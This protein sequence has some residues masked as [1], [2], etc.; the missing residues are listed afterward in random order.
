MRMTIFYV[1]ILMN[2]FSFCMAD[3][4]SWTYLLYNS[5]ISET[6][7]LTLE[8]KGVKKFL[9]QPMCETKILLAPNT[10]YSQVEISP[11]SKSEKDY[12]RNLVSEGVL[13]PLGYSRTYVDAKGDVQVY[14]ENYESNPNLY[15][16]SPDDFHKVLG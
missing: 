4:E 13:V 16:S 15:V 12:L 6:S 7:K 11:T 9:K 14:R 2:F 5:R 8:S 10:N 1:L 3:D